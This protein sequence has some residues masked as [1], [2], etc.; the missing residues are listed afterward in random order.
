MPEQRCPNRENLI[1]NDRDLIRDTKAPLRSYPSQKARHDNVRRNLISA[2]RFSVGLRALG[3][4][5][6]GID[7]VTFHTTLKDLGFRFGGFVAFWVFYIARYSATTV[8]GAQASG[9]NATN[10]FLMP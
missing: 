7:D 1:S 8:R 2:L 9:A 4:P 5:G 6:Q 3:G 10:L